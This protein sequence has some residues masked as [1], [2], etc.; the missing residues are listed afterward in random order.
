MSNAV[1]AG[2]AMILVEECRLRFD[3]PVDA[4]LSELANRKVLRRLDGPIDDTD[5]PGGPSRSVTFSRCAWV[6]LPH[7]PDGAQLPGHEDRQSS[8]E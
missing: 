2:A 6:G 7:D 4:F 3:D 5:P 1:T 8:E